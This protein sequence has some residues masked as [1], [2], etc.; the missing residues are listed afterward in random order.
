MNILSNKYLKSGL[1]MKVYYVSPQGRGP[2]YEKNEGTLVVPSGVQKI[3][4]GVFSLKCSRR[5]LLR[6]LLAY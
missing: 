5:K 1:P 2:S 6:Y 4:V 3:P